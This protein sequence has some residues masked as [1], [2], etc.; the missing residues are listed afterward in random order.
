MAKKNHYSW[1]AY[2]KAIVREYPA[3]QD[4]NLHGVAL[5]EY[6]AVRDAVDT[7]ERMTDAV[8]RMSVIRL[9]HFER[10]HTLEGAALRIPC[11]RSLAAKWQRDFFE[12][13]ARNCGLLDLGR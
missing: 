8:S 1:W 11:S 6:E 9:V 7:T 5:R 2:I 10:T 3:R 12:E 4:V 13:V